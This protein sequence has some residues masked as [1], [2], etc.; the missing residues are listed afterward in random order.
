MHKNKIV[1]DVQELVKLL[2]VVSNFED[3][4]IIYH[5][6]EQG[7]SFDVIDQELGV[8]SGKSEREYQAFKEM[9]ENVIIAV[10]LDEAVFAMDFTPGDVILRELRKIYRKGG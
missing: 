10:A 1:R 7:Y 4:P 9:V 2:C 5:M 6:I 8:D 3:I